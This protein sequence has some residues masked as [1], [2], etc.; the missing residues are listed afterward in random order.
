MYGVLIYPTYLKQLIIAYDVV[1]N[2]K[3]KQYVPQFPGV[4]NHIP[5]TQI[6]LTYFLNVCLIPHVF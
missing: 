1:K 6:I 2:L 4:K 3:V 5:V